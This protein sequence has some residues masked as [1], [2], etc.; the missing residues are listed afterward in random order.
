MSL[1]KPASAKEGLNAPHDDQAIFKHPDPAQSARLFRQK[2]YRITLH[3]GDRTSGT[4]TRAMFNVGDLMSQW[5]LKG[6]NLDAGNKHWNLTVEAFTLSAVEALP[7]MLEVKALNFPTFSETWS[8]DAQGA[9]SL[10]CIASGATN[11]D[12][13]GNNSKG[14]TL[15]QLPRGNIGIAIVDRL[16]QATLDADAD[17]AWHIVLSLDPFTVEHL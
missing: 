6:T 7:T 8:S 11:A 4:A 14:I 9:G 1:Y 10:L 5:G 2:T 13:L 17:L 15:G 16:D 3:S 12:F